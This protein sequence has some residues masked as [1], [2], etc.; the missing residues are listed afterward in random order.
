MEQLLQAH[1]LSLEQRKQAKEGRFNSKIE[2]V[3]QMQSEMEQQKKIAY[4]MRQRMELKKMQLKNEL[5][6]V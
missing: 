2:R 4:E 3:S 5:R 6:S 1:N